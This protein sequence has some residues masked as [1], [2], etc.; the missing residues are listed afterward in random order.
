M[1]AAVVWGGY[2][3]FRLSYFGLP[4]PHTYYAK[5]GRGFDIERWFVLFTNGASAAEM[6]LLCCGL[7]SLFWVPTFVGYTLFGLI[8]ARLYFIGSVEVDWM[9]NL[10]HFQPIYL[11]FILLF[12]TAAHHIFQADDPRRARGLT[13]ILLLSL[14]YA[15]L[16]IDSRF[17]PWDFKSHG[18]EKGLGAKRQNRPARYLDA[19][20]RIP[21][22]CQDQR[23]GRLQQAYNVMSA[24][25]DPMSKDW[26][27]GRDIGRLGWLTPSRS[28]I[29]L[30]CLPH[31][32]PI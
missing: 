25:A 10:R 12:I 27:I 31:R 9:P 13:L 14:S 7:L 21:R 18:A 8:I 30:A 22:T 2:E 24:S 1:I 23:S 3:V 26:Y 11:A 17:G 19:L 6:L 15:W 20:R 5:P 29:Q 16:P 4:F 28:S 32:R